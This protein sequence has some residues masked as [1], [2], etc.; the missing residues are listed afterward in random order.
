MTLAIR[1]HQSFIK[2]LS[3]VKRREEGYFSS[4]QSAALIKLIDTSQDNLHKMDILSDLKEVARE[5]STDG[6]D[7]YGASAVLPGSIYYSRQ[8]LR[9]LPPTFPAPSFTV[10][11]DGEIA[12]EWDYGVRKFISVSIGRDGTLNYAGLLGHRSFHGE[13]PL[14]WGIPKR[15]MAGIES[16]VC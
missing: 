7:G 13:E 2:S 9:L 16:I 5:A 4:G 11:P 3:V 1:R 15:I 6:W 8:F 10:D 12:I 14:T